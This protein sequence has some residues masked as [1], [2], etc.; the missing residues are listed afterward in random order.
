M[1]LQLVLSD[2]EC[3]D[4]AKILF[5]KI[6]VKKNAINF[7]KYEK[8]PTRRAFKPIFLWLYAAVGGVVWRLEPNIHI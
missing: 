4:R 1:N 2:C 3:K 5:S 7:K 8:Y 6:F